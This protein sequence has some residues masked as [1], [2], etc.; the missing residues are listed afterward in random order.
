MVS[1]ELKTLHVL[2]Y[3]KASSITPDYFLYLLCR[4]GITLQ[5]RQMH[6]DKTSK[7]QSKIKW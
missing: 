4:N 2:F 3:G 1:I 7:Q 6:L 5:K